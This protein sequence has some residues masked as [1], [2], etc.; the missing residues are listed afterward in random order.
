MS[1]NFLSFHLTPLYLTTPHLVSSY[2]PIYSPLSSLSS[3]V[4]VLHILFS[5]SFFLTYSTFL[6]LIPYLPLF[7]LFFPFF[8]LPL[9]LS[10]HVIVFLFFF[11]IPSVFLVKIKMSPMILRYWY[12]TTHTLY[13]FIYIYQYVG[14]GNYWY[15]YIHEPICRCVYTQSQVRSQIT[16]HLKCAKSAQALNN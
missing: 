2:L 9:H 5:L 10:P 3:F 7:D 16:W 14:E 11:L 12:L 8:D 6:S 13:T 15:I 1:T 4:P